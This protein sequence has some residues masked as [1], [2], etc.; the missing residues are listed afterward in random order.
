MRETINCPSEHGEMTLSVA[1]Q[2]TTFRGETISYQIEAYVCNECGLSIGT[3]EQTATIQNAITD[4][5]RKKVGLLTGKEIKEKR[6][7]KKWS[8]KELAKRAGVGIASIK[9]WENGVI[10]TKSMDHALKSA[11]Q[12][13]RIGN[14]NTGNREKM[15]FPR[16]KLV[17]KKFESELGFGFLNEG[18]ML[19]FDAKYLWYADMV[20]FK[21]L[22]KSITGSPYAALPHGPQ[23]N[24]YKELVELIR[25]ADESEAEPLTEDEKRIIARV[26]LTF[27]TKQMVFDAAHKEIIWGNRSPGELIP[28]SDAEKLTEI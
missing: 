28:Y 20:A 2:E 25:V 16:I 11:F 12:G 7:E 26:A 13:Y 9:R 15:L 4:A 18:D 3:I 21:E 19:L 22:G 14:I 27:P 10:Q 23:L 6:A 5:Y 1:D 8:Q 17:F 24:N